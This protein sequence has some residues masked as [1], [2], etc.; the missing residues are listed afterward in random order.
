MVPMKDVS[1]SGLGTRGIVTT[2]GLLQIL[3]WG[4][5][6][7]LLAVLGR[8]IAADTGWPFAGVIGG[9]SLALLVA[10]LVSPFVGRTI[11][12]RGGRPVLAA[13]AA[14]LALGLAGMALSPN[15]PTYLLAWAVV[16]CG[17]SASLYDP[18]FSTLGQLYGRDARRLI[19]AVTLFGGFSSTLAWP[20]T[21]FLLD[22]VGW[23]ATCAT[24]AALEL[25]IGVSAYLLLLPRRAKAARTSAASAKDASPELPPHKQS[26][27]LFLLGTI[28]PIGGGLLSLLSTHLLV[29][30]QARGLELAAAVALGALVGPSQVTARIL[31]M[32]FGH[33]YH[34]VWT[35]LTGAVLFAI[36]MALLWS[37]W[38]LP[39]LALIAYGL[40][41]GVSSIARGT[42]PLVLF[43]PAGYPEVMGKLGLPSLLAM[44]LAP[45]VGAP[46][47][48]YGGAGLTF[49]ALTL[50]ASVNVGLAL[51]LVRLCRA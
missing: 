39:A 40:G 11:A 8:P 28:L 37:G 51:I 41:N 27:A 22:H 43:G 34:P 46:L 23:R 2:L 36:G 14:L 32:S 3:A 15:L 47:I 24:Y 16:G 38:P 48:E 49:A 1:P 6:F 9:V 26:L 35:M 30:L 7:Y 19:T 10:G 33:R 5:T 25:G 42:V 17:M 31:E 20:S 29:L 13:G 12:V 45:A 21:A 18:A 44:A 4:S 50:M